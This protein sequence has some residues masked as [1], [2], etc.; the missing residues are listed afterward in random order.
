MQDFKALARLQSLLALAMMALLAIIFLPTTGTSD[1]CDWLD[2][3]RNVYENGLVKGYVINH[4]EHPPYFS[5]ILYVAFALA[6][7]VGLA[8]FYGL[9][10]LFLLFLCVS[11]GI[12][13]IWSNRNA[14]LTLIFFVPLAY[15]CL[16]LSYMDIFFTP[17]FLASVY[18]LS[19]EKLLPAAIFFAC[20]S[21]V[22]YPVLIVAPFFLAY[23][24]F[25]SIKKTSSI[26]GAAQHIAVNAVLPAAAILLITYTIF[27][28][29][30]LH[31]LIRGFGHNCL[32]CNAMNFNRL[33]SVIQ[34]DFYTD[35]NLWTAILRKTALVS[36]YNQSDEILYTIAQ[37]GFIAFYA[38]TFIT[39]LLREKSIQTFLVFS[40]TGHFCY[41]ILSKGVHENHLY[42]SMLLAMC[43][44]IIDSR[45]LAMALNIILISS[46]NL[47]VNYG[48]NGMPLDLWW[49]KSFYPNEVPSLGWLHAGYPFDKNIILS[50]FDT[51]YFFM[52][53]LFV[54]FSRTKNTVP[55]AS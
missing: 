55:L 1:I 53:W 21:M 3:G 30:P 16:A 50:L 28:V 44:A 7:F 24:I 29:E 4:H 22:K 13:Y 33:S 49:D 12:L 39:F 27:G 40:I 52:F 8:P 36:S 17:F 14:A 45:F 10:I 43:L 11:V 37:A 26:T 46:L 42:L 31:A 20:A 48:I 47:F 41:F 18:F 51:A 15:S 9:K 19:K 38:I 23:G 34:Y 32:S 54:V 35:Q 5:V 6:K 2:W 25:L